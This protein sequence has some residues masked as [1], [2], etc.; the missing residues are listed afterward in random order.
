MIEALLDVLSWIFITAG[1][2]FIVSGAVG[3]LRM[4]DVYTRLHAASI[5]DTLGMGLLILGFLLQAGSIFV[6][7]KL[8]F[9]FVLF[10]FVGPVATHATA[11]AAL[12]A[13]VYPIL[14]EDRRDRALKKKKQ[15]D[16]GEGGQE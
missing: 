15:K 16:D 10:F 14:K 3:I 9:V 4:P 8:V 2:F 11:Q 1:S 7:V 6:A 5:I 13:G 12:H